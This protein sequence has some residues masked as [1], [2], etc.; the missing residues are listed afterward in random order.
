MRSLLSKKLADEKNELGTDGL[1]KLM[2]TLGGIVDA[3][4]K[5]LGLNHRQKVKP[6]RQRVVM[7]EPILEP[8]PTSLPE[9]AGG[10]AL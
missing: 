6:R 2:S 8:T 5:L 10:D 3:E 9:G 4:N 7:P 1:A